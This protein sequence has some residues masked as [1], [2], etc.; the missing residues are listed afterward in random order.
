[1]PTLKFILK[2]STWHYSKL[3]YTATCSWPLFEKKKKLTSK[4]ASLKKEPT[5]SLIW[6]VKRLSLGKLFWQKKVEKSK[7]N[8][9]TTAIFDQGPNTT[10]RK[11]AKLQNP[12]KQ[13]WKALMGS[14]AWILFFELFCYLEHQHWRFIRFIHLKYVFNSLPKYHHSKPESALKREQVLNMILL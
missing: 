4:S 2:L 12:L 5:K 7:K 8:L 9:H 6:I 1:M 11:S 13:N 14:L 10:T 3:I